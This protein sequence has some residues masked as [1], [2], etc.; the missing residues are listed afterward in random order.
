MKKRMKRTVMGGQGPPPTCAWA[1]AWQAAYLLLQQ[2]MRWDE[3]NDA[4]EKRRVTV[5]RERVR[6][7][8]HWGGQHTPCGG[9]RWA[10]GKGCR[11][12][13]G[14]QDSV[15]PGRLSQALQGQRRGV[16]GYRHARHCHVS[17]SCPTTTQQTGTKA[18]LSP[19]ATKLGATVA[20]PS[21]T[22]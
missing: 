17:S 3:R 21:L 10:T 14:M 19:L 18:R 13:Q 15:C 9:S 1:A 4:T 22:V 5:T 7:T 2:P 8:T 11:A 16:D 12:Q 6:D 20:G